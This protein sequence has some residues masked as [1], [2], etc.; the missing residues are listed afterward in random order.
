MLARKNLPVKRSYQLSKSARSSRSLRV[1][2]GPKSLSV[3]RSSRSRSL[4]NCARTKMSQ[5]CALGPQPRRCARTKGL[6]VLLGPKVSALC[7]GRS[8]SVALGPK[9]S[10]MCARA[11]VAAS[12]IVLGPK[13]SAMCAR[14]AA[15]ALRSDQR[16]QRCAWTKG[17]SVVLGPKPRRCT[18]AKCHSFVL[19]STA[20]ALCL[21]HR[22]QSSGRSPT[23]VVF[24]TPNFVVRMV[25]RLYATT[26]SVAPNRG[27]PRG[28]A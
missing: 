28:K 25:P 18:G 9:V 12:A 19:R 1:V 24:V 13:V 8:L 23:F 27:P 3:V 11:A 10:A 5:R 21:D 17:L 7:S 26:V 22:T 6:S 2:F 16:S 14:A 4:S 15:S 20:A